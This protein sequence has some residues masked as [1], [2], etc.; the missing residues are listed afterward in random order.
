MGSTTSL[1]V[2]KNSNG[3]SVINMLHVSDVDSGQT[4]TWTEKTAPSHGTLTI[5]GATAASG[6]SDITPAGTTTYTPTAGYSGSDSF[7]I[8]VS[9]GT[10]TA[11]RTITV[12]VKAAIIKLI[13]PTGLAWDTTT[14]GKATWNAD[15][16]ASG[17]SVQLYKGGIAQGI[18]VSVTTLYNDFSST[19]EA[20]GNGTYTFRVTAK[21][22][23]INYSGSDVSAVS[24]GY[25]YNTAPSFVGSTEALTV[26]ES[27]SGN[28]VK[29]M[30]HVSDVDSG[31]MLT[32]TEQTAPSHGT[33]TITGA[34]ATSGTSDITP[35][36]TTTYTPTAG[37]SGS[38]SF[39]IQV[40]D[41]TATATRTITVTV[42]AAIT[43]TP[44]LTGTADIAGS[45]TSAAT[46]AVKKTYDASA[47][48]PVLS[49]KTQTTV[50]LTSVTGYE[51]VRVS[52][53]ADVSTGTWQDSNVFSGL[54]S[55]TEYD[56]YQ[57]IKET[58]TYKASAI[59]G[60]L[61]VVTEA[62][63]EPTPTTKPDPTTTPTTTPTATPAT[64]TSA[65]TA[66]A[67]TRTITGTL[68]DSNDNPMAGYVVELHSDPI[69]TITDAN[70]QYTFHNVD[71]TSHELIVKTAEGEKIAEFELAFSEGKEFST[72]MTKEGVNI[73]YTLNTETVNIE[74]KMTPDQSGAAISRVSGSKIPQT[75]NS[76][77]GF[78]SVLW[79]VGG[80]A[81][82]L[83]LITLLIIVLLKKKRKI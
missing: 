71:Y 64:K 40:S 54:L 9:D 55:G 4:L 12:T 57:R 42:T 27:S 82:A 59:S 15:I 29:N 63:P 1:T 83:M 79:W 21:G 48:A 34:T 61:D 8:Q 31:Q 77:G 11:T 30:L 53:G 78:G 43:T 38:D 75:S 25:V 74:I 81:L 67:G 5:T 66:A 6:T 10:A 22:D 28:S 33:L 70:G 19:I 24:S 32:W 72:V 16:G 26:D 46:T 37:Y 20:S 65:E 62:L 73:T 80:G 23:G 36:G 52:N 18:A 76:L 17:Y 41:G 35:G 13:A 58:T 49:S 39:T 69:T 7:A 45:V 56:F 51:Y 44:A 68:L 60:K 2:D 14:P 47:V 3:N 50:T